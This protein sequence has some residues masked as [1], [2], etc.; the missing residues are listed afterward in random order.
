MNTEFPYGPAITLLETIENLEPRRNLDMNIHH[1]II[2]NGHKK[3]KQPKFPSAD[4]WL[5]KRCYVHMFIIY[6]PAIKKER[7]ADIC[8]DMDEPWKCH[9]K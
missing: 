7:S 2:H 5:N 9:A 3:W 1:S 4:K 8:K 6:Y